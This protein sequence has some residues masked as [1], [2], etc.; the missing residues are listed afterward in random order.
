MET[1]MVRQK[2]VGAK[3]KIEITANI[4]NEFTE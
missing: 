2:N 3:I 4:Q 1:S